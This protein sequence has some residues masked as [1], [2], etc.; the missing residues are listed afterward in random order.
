[1]K[2]LVLLCEKI[3]NRLGTYSLNI[4]QSIK[5]A[6]LKNW[7]ESII[8][9]II[10]FWRHTV[11]V[12][13]I[14]LLLYYPIGGLLINKIDDNSNLNVINKTGEINSINAVI[15]LINR[16]VEQNVWTANQPFFFPAAILDN[17]P[18]YQTGIISALADFIDIWNFLDDSS[19]N[20]A[21]AS[22]FL[23]YPSNI[24][25][26]DF[27]KSWLPLASTNK[28]YRNASQELV[29]YN[30]YIAQNGLPFILKSSTL[31]TILQQINN[32]LLA[33]VSDIQN[34]ITSGSKK[35]IDFDSDNVFYY[36][37]GSCY[38]YYII[39]KELENDY[40]NVIKAQNIENEWQ[41]MLDLIQEASLLNPMIVINAAPD[42]SFLPSH[43]TAQGFYL[44]Q[45]SIKINKIIQNLNDR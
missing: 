17:M 36:G 1:M 8:N 29:F 15:K 20:L 33:A 28:Q 40:I 16:E 3:K 37:K 38:G 39:L 12:L 27:S 9:L 44:T 25:I 42:A 11:V 45:S 34:Q 43:L 19:E 24:W 31:K 26:I 30:S 7:G 35:I 13:G 21:R 2:P 18:A 22:D 23:K 4:I 6:H 14:I 10:R 41:E 32:H 5:N